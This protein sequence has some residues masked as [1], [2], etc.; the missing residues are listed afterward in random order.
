VEDTGSTVTVNGPLAATMADLEI[1]YRVL[2]K[3][4]SSDPIAALFT[5]PEPL[6]SA[7]PKVIGIYKDWFDRAEPSVHALCTKFV[8]HCEKSLGYT[9]VPITIP[10]CPE[11]QLAHAMTIV[12]EM[13]SRAQAPPF[14]PS[15]YLSDLT[16]SNK[17]LLSMGAYTPARDYLLAQQLRNLLMQHLSFLFKKYPGLIIVTPTTPIPG[18]EI[19]HEGDLEHGAFDANKSIRNMEYVWLANFTGLPGISCPVGY[20]DPKKGEG[21]VPVGIMGAGEWGG[22]ETLIEFGK[23]A[24]AWLGKENAGGGRK[25]PKNWVDVVTVAKERVDGSVV[26]GSE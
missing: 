17:I 3:P 9:V 24:E 15:N 8:D 22:E 20:V 4:N 10:Y 7:R 16:P 23:E 12:A 14:S 5:P 6:H 13:T 19:E 11:G 21:K 2:A 1:A 25:L 18:W 26:E